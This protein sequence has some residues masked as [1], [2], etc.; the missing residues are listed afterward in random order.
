MNA[1]LG[2]SKDISWVSLAN[3]LGLSVGFLVVGRLSDIFGR[4]WFF[5]GG[6][7]LATLGS[8]INSVVNSING[9]IVG[10]CLL[11]VA[12]AVQISFT[13]AVSELVPNKHRPIVVAAVFSS[14][15]E[16]AAFGP[17][18]AQSL[19]VNTTAG[20]RWIYYLNIIVT[21]GAALDFFL[22]YHPPNF[23]LLHQNTTTWQQFKRLDF[24]GFVLFTGGL[25]LFI[26]GLSW[27]GSAYPWKSARVISTIV[28]G[29]VALSAFIVHE[30]YFHKGDPLLPLYLFK[31]PGYLAMVITATVGSCIYYSQGIIWPEQ[32]LYLFPGTPVHNGWLAC[33]LG[34]ATLFG[35]IFGGAYLRLVPKT[36]WL[37]IPSCF[38]LI[39][40]SAAMVS[41][42]PGQQTSAIAI[43]FMLAFFTGIIEIASLGLIPLAC[44]T[45][46]IG[47]AVG[48]LGS[49]RSGGATVAT[50]IFTTILSNK[51]NK[52]LPQYVVPVALD[53]GVSSPGDL[54]T[55]ISELTAGT[56]E[57][58]PGLSPAMVEEVKTAN[59]L[60]WT[61][62]FKY[63]LFS[64]LVV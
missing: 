34:S 56:L 25:V 9:L 63:V 4:R 39:A 15:V 5:I 54:A 8:I 3:T 38:S 30:A 29:F 32:I 44:P 47:V 7:L 21:G 14:G 60:A 57:T 22:F 2:P 24:P 31:K 48:A 36:R 23:H 18:V 13:F 26:M 46:D 52:F 40:F 16:F 19:I 41:I 35:E 64:L 45:E 37:V 51:I 28:L 6:N 49:I 59:A 58:F 43:L 12:G 53:A 1:S 11:G 10:S 20:W 50:A 42:K 27:G 62:S 17:V 55:L 33:V 61:E